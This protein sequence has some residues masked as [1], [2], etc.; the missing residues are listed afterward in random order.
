MSSG[1]KRIKT[2]VRADDSVLQTRTVSNRW[3][4]RSTMP[5]D[6]N[7]Q[8]IHKKKKKRMYFRNNRSS[9]LRRDG[10]RRG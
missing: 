6:H 10:T 5:A 3:P 4:R 7:E 9:V 2:L 8:Y 1:A